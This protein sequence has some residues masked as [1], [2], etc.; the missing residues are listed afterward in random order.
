MFPEAS[1]WAAFAVCLALAACRKGDGGAAREDAGIAPD[2]APARAAPRSWMCGDAAP[3]PADAPALAPLPG[4]KAKRLGSAL[5]LEPMAVEAKLEPRFLGWSSEVLTE[6][7]ELERV[8]GAVGEWNTI[9]API[10][11]AAL[12]FEACIAHVG[13][14]PWLENASYADMTYRIYALRQPVEDV[15]RAIL[16]RAV[17]EAERIGCQPPHRGAAA[18]WIDNAAGEGGWERIDVTV[19]L[20][21][22]DYGG[23]AH[24]DVRARR[25]GDATVAAVFLYEAGGPDGE[26]RQRDVDAVLRGIREVKGEGSP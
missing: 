15:R 3:A 2:A 17:R 23:R 10:V 25:F 6:R 1:R 14:E 11:D 16:G 9:Y 18:K 26:P 20:W 22:S 24:V 7:G 5:K 21:Y 12:P 19:D 8:R 4:A 13:E